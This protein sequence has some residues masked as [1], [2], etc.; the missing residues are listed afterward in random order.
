MSEVEIIGPCPLC[1][2]PQEDDYYRG[3]KAEWAE[4][5][6]AQERFDKLRQLVGCDACGEPIGEGGGICALDNVKE[7]TG[8]AEALSAVWEQQ[9]AKAMALCE[10]A[11]DEGK[12]YRACITHTIEVAKRYEGAEC[13][14]C[15][16]LVEDVLDALQNNQ[17]NLGQA[18]AEEDA[19]LQAEEDAE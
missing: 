10:R 1:A 13:E 8:A 12:D 3:I 4:L 5:K 15:A 6:T 16:G 11:I 2:C 17:W 9:H 19:R 7:A 14:E 18:M